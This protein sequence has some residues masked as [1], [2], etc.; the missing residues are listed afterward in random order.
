[1]T[2]VDFGTAVGEGRLIRHRV[3]ALALVLLVAGG[4]GRE[5]PRGGTTSAQ[6][7]SEAPP[8]ASSAAA[9]PA[10][11][12]P[13]PTNATASPAV[14]VTVA[15]STAHDAILA[16]GRGRSLYLLEEDPAGGSRCTEMCAVVWPPYLASG[17][18]PAA[19]SGV[20]AS[21]LGTLTRPGGGTQ[22]SYA[23]RALYYYIG[24][25]RPGDTRGQHVEDSWGEWYLVRPD[26]A[27]VRAPDRDRGGRRGRGGRDDR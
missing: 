25:A 27:E 23:G 14:R 4:C 24:D 18:A 9:P 10:S 11:A 21:L 5:E 20:R 12:A 3:P 2:A 6:P 16:D 8:P 17:G 15:R 26:G 13:T 22:V 7:S 19:D 1:M